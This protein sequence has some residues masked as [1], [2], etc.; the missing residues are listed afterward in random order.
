MCSLQGSEE[1]LRKESG[2]ATLPRY[3][4]MPMVIVENHS[5]EQLAEKT[6]FACDVVAGEEPRWADEIAQM[7]EELAKN[8]CPGHCRAILSALLE[9]KEGTYDIEI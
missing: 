5:A 1:N 7:K 6:L 2:G 9:M 4:T 8:P 3:K